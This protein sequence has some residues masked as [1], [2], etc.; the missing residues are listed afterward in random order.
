[1]SYKREPAHDIA[2]MT[3]EE[4]VVLMVRVVL[5]TFYVSHPLLMWSIFGLE[6]A[7]HALAAIELPGSAAYLL[8]AAEVLGGAMLFLGMLVRRVAIGLL[9]VALAAAGAHFATGLGA[10]LAYGAFVAAC[11]AGQALLASAI[12]A[13]KSRAA[14]EP[15]APMLE[16]FRLHT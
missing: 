13:P 2:L 3:P 7:T 15:D 11:V 12:L 10:N 14:A 6:H 4:Y 9:P 16:E 1:M 5:G 8:A